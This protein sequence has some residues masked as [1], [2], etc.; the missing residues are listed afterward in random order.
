MKR[1]FALWPDRFVNRNMRK[2]DCPGLA[3]LE[4]EPPDGA[5]DVT[6]LPRLVSGQ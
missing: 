3:R 2:R 4:P 5:H 6:R 1:T